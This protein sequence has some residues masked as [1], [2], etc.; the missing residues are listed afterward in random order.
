MSMR[1]RLEKRSRGK[2][3]WRDEM[4][5]LTRKKWRARKGREDTK[6]THRIFSPPRGP[7][8]GRSPLYLHYYSLTT[9]SPHPFLS[10]ITPSW[11]LPL[12][13]GNARY[14]SPQ[15]KRRVWQWQHCTTPSILVQICSRASNKG[16]GRFITMG[17]IREGCRRRRQP[18]NVL[19]AIEREKKGANGYH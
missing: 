18:K 8:E 16:G 5:L 15:C 2:G 13:I 9:H 4:V 10:H 7:L 3:R 12:S 17:S 6:E 19:E 11:P 1:T 14:I